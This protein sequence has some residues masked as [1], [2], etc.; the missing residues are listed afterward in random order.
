MSDVV[1]NRKGLDKLIKILSGPKAIAKVGIV[2]DS[3]REDGKSNAEVGAMQ[4]FGTSTI[5]QRSFIKVPLSTQLKSEIE[6]SQ[7]F[8]KK[9]L[10]EISAANSLV[11]WAQIMGEIGEK[12]VIGAFDSQGYGKWPANKQPGHSSLLDSQQLRDSISY[13]IKEG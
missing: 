11:P 5:P 10:D 6:N 12:V 9:S 7:K 8:N 2:G 13:E 4:E 1:L 3:F